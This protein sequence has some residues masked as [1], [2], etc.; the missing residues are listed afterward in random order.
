MITVTILISFDYC[1]L[2]NNYDSCSDVIVFDKN[3]FLLYDVVN[4]DAH[5][6]SYYYHII[7]VVAVI[8]VVDDDDDYNDNG[9]DDYFRKP[10]FP[11]LSMFSLVMLLQFLLS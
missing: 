6:S 11:L 1:F 2:D 8:V 5:S 4:L 3:S 9:E 10:H 7:L